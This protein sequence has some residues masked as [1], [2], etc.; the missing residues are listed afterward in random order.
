[1]HSQDQQGV[2][3]LDTAIEV[4]KNDTRKKGHLDS[5]INSTSQLNHS[6]QRRLLPPISTQTSQA[7]SR[8]H[9]AHQ[10]EKHLATTSIA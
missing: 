7:Y 6:Q 3:F 5:L 9:S 2:A 8:L 10:H 4:A 1:V